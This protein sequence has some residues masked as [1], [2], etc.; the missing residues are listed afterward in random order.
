MLVPGVAKAAALMVVG[1]ISLGCGRNMMETLQVVHNTKNDIVLLPSTSMS[2]SPFKISS[3][4]PDS[5]SI[6]IV[7]NNNNYS[8]TTTTTTTTATIT[9]EFLQKLTRKQVLQLYFHTCQAPTNTTLLEGPW[10]GV[11]L[12]N[13]GFFLTRISGFVTNYL[14]GKQRRWNGK[15]FDSSSHAGINRFETFVQ[16]KYTNNKNNKNNQYSPTSKSKHSCLIVSRTEEDHPFCWSIQDSSI[17]QKNKAAIILRYNSPYS[18]FTKSQW[19]MSIGGGTKKIHT[20]HNN[21]ILHHQ[22]KHRSIIWNTMK[23]EIRVV[24]GTNNTILIGLGSLQ[25]SGGMI[26]AAPFCLYRTTMD[27]YPV[28]K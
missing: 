24:P 7:N 10:N 2:T 22:R 19:R 18:T 23:D 9:K 27:C 13:N 4:A 17:L 14:F 25:W 5:N 21:N 12:Q 1:S 3:L 28:P 20:N 26:N 6:G 11:L 16:S 15:F 8:S